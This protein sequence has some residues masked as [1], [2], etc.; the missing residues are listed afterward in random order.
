MGKDG[1]SGL[2]FDRGE[3]ISA[4]GEFARGFSWPGDSGINACLWQIQQARLAVVASKINREKYAGE[5]YPPAH[6]A[7][8]DA[9]RVSAEHKAV[10]ALTANLILAD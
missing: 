6:K 7:G 9:G 10:M 3:H 5:R 2:V 1:F 8:T 4:R